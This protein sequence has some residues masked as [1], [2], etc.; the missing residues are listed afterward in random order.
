MPDAALAIDAAGNDRLGPSLLQ[1]G[2]E[3]VGVITPIGGETL[4]ARCVFEEVVGGPDVGRIAG[5]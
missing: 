3:T 5:R 1:R 2:A 4:E